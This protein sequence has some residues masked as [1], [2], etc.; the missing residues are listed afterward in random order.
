MG[1]YRNRFPGSYIYSSARSVPVYWGHFSIVE[2][3]L[4]CLTD[5]MVNGRNWS[6]AVNMAGS[7]VMMFTNRELVAN[8]SANMGR[9]Y[10][11]SFPLPEGN[12]FR[13]KYQHKYDNPGRGQR[14]GDHD[15]PPFN[16]TIYK[17]AK[18]WRLPRKFVTFLLDHPVA[19]T[20][21]GEPHFVHPLIRV[22]LMRL[23]SGPSS[24][25]LLMN[26]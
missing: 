19:K 26:M 6:Y 24:H 18:S 20:Y 16:L 15:P 12:Q 1:C 3:E 8:I 17:G 21:L 7:E 23:Q 13:V 2:A 25:I 14:L 22:I 11:E 4:L 5:L 9:I 10:T